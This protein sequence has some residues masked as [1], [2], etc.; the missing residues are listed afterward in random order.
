MLHVPPRH[1]RRAGYWRRVVLGVVAVAHRRLAP[2]SSATTTTTERVLPSSAVQV[3]LSRPTTT[4]RLPLASDSATCLA[5]SRHT[6]TVK[7]DAFCSG[8]P[9]TATRN[10]AQAIPLGCRCT[11][12]RW[13]WW[14]PSVGCAGA[15]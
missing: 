9:D 2:S 14:P 4:T 1:I 6:T 3:L 8:R 7:N 13:S 5:W 12:R 11:T 15:S 10:I